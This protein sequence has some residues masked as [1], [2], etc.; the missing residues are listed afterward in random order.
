AAWSRAPAPPSAACSSWYRPDARRRSASP[1]SLAGRRRVRR[2]ALRRLPQNVDVQD[3]LP[4]L[5]LEL[6]DLL[7]LERL[8]VLRPGP[9]GVLR[10]PPRTAPA[11]SRFRRGQT[12][13]ARG[14]RHTTPQDGRA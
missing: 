7:V 4:D 13:L 10:P 5:L 12:L 3:Q 14:L 1:A 2:A 8:V 11:N 6:L 9:Q